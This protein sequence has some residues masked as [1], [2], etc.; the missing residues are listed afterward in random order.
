MKM[1]HIIT[2][3][4]GYGGTEKT[5][6][7]YLAGTDRRIVEHVVFVLKSCGT[8]NTVG[9]AI[10]DL[11]VPVLEFGLQ[12]W[13]NVLSFP[14][15]FIRALRATRP[16]V[17]SAWLYHPIFTAEL[18]RPFAVGSP[19]VVWHIRNLP[20]YAH[21]PGFRNS[22]RRAFLRLVGLL[23]H[24]SDALIVANSTEAMTAHQAIGYRQ[25]GWHVV[26]NGIDFHGYSPDPGRR[27]SV[28]EALGIRDDEIVVT[29]VGR[30][31][32]EKGYGHLF[33]AVARSAVLQ[34]LRLQGKL[35]FLG[36]GQGVSEDNAAFVA[37]C[38]PVFDRGSRNLLGRQED[39][40]SY[41]AAGD[42]FILSSVSESFPNVL[43]E[44]MASGLPVVATQ[45]GGVA[46]LGLDPAALATPTDSLSIAHAIDR[47]LSLDAE[48]RAE[49]TRRQQ[50]V[51][52][53]RY[54]TQLMNRRFDELLLGGDA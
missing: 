27:R 52:R 50:E 39:V 9:S 29:A 35:R 12:S 3:L 17:I 54:S 14:F 25:A 13:P 41:L 46:D 49:I 28:R 4:N 15:R 45:V 38:A 26:R 30:F 6:L 21:G 53:E 11:G 18:Y 34:S 20:S 43:I 19:R 32:P 1:V 48:H 51:V 22:F 47:V 8:Q 23:S 37:L 7:R 42:L 36:V 31:V 24:R 10:R 33:E 5:L 44:A 2:D 40:Q 16:D